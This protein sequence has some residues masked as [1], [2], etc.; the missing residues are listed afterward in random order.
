MAPRTLRRR[1]AVLPCAAAL[2][3]LLLAAAA[4]APVIGTEG[5]QGEEKFIGW[6]GETYEG[7]GGG[8]RPWCAQD[9]KGW[10]RGVAPRSKATQRNSTGKTPRPFPTFTTP[11]QG[12][13]PSRGARARLS[14]TAFYP[15]PSASTSS[16]SP[17]RA[18]AGRRSS[19]PTAA[20]CS[21]LTAPATAASSSGLVV[22]VVE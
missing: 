22:V 9:N 3:P 11:K 16:A 6:G 13:K 18:C 20:A 1:R 4:L 15:T 19:R 2:L 8:D 10:C 21:T 5:Q 12:S 7:G 14:T 17:R